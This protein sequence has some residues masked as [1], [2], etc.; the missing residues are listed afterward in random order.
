MKLYGFPLSQPTRSIL[1]L[2]K[3][4]SIPYHLV[5]ID[6]TKGDT[7]KKEFRSI[8]P[9][10][11]V[12]FI[13]DDG[14][15]LGESGAILQYICE[16]HQLHHWYPQNVHQ[17]AQ[18]NFWIHWNHFNTRNSTIKLL[19]KFLWPPKDV[20]Q[21]VALAEGR[22][23]LV[24]SLTFLEHKLTISPEARFLASKSFPTIADL[25]ILPELD[26]QTERAFN[27]LDYS[28]YPKVRT[29]MDETKQ[30]IECYEE[31][32]QPVVDVANK[33]KK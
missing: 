11:L 6:A 8:N 29:W 19:R 5:L 33:T 9:Q 2:C 22:A 7:R 21:D 28:N 1:M 12:P 4:A 23:S 17:R 20:A 14:F 10:G 30:A 15:Q 3:E 27:L 18:I 31:V 32:F 26:Q 16:K 13:D 25:F 24:K